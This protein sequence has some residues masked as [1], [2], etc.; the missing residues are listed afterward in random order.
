MLGLCIATPIQATEPKTAN[1]MNQAMADRFSIK[2]D[3][4]EEY[5]GEFT[6]S[7]YCSCEKCNGRWTGQ[8]AKNGQE[9]IEGYTIAVDT[10]VIDLNTWVR[11]DGYGKFKACDTG[12]AIVGNKIDIYMSDHEECLKKGIV[13]KIK[14][15]KMLSKE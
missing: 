1:Q 12:S 14:V 15:Y 13:K 9:L 8:P 6:L 7:F 3:K 4:K 11:I 2:E 5:L 10:D